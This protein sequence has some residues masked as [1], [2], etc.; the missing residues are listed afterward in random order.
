MEVW[1][2]A[3]TRACV[4][5]HVWMCTVGTDLSDV[6]CSLKTCQINQMMDEKYLYNSMQH[7][8]FPSLPS[9]KSGFRINMSDK[10]ELTV[11]A[12]VCV[13]ACERACVCV[14]A[15]VRVCR[16]VL[17]VV[18]FCYVVITVVA[19][20]S[21]LLNVP[22]LQHMQRKSLSTVEILH[23]SRHTLLLLPHV[24]VLTSAHVSRHVF[25][26][27]SKLNHVDHRCWEAF[28]QNHF[29][30]HS[31]ETNTFYTR[32]TVSI[33]FYISFVLFVI[34]RTYIIL[35]CSYCSGTHRN[36]Y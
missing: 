3:R 32:H 21:P 1:V 10:S 23:Y 19:Y 20:H 24:C 22:F 31:C 12:C 28:V 35:Y 26:F 13:C 2:H 18:Y 6:I 16:C 8:L 33:P 34:F 7:F 30:I 25:V 27:S 36:A 5:V 14:C 11:Y 15:C 9:D 4:L 17:P 29:S